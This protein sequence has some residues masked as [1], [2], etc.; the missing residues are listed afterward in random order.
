MRSRH[1]LGGSRW[2]SDNAEAQ[3]RSCSYAMKVMNG[4]DAVVLSPRRD[5]EDFTLG[6]GSLRLGI[7]RRC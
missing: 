4:C 3:K 6:I 2:G 1:A 7:G 5:L